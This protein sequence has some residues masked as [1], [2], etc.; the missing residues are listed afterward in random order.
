V[1]LASRRLIEIEGMQ[2]LGLDPTQGEQ[3]ASKFI[4]IVSDQSLTCGLT[5]LQEYRL[6]NKQAAF[7]HLA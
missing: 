3:R 6:V 5:W 7:K 2:S 1:P 4:V